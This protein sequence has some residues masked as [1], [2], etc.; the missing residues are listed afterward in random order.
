MTPFPVSRESALTAMV[1]TS[2]SLTAAPSMVNPMVDCALTVPDRSIAVQNGQNEAIIFLI[3]L[4]ICIRFILVSGYVSRN[5]YVP[6]ID[7]IKDHQGRNAF[8]SKMKAIH[9]K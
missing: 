8:S 9:Y 5:T 2:F 7:K 1:K 3:N 4:F 6:V